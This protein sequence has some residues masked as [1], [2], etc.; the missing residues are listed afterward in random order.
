MSAPWG[1]YQTERAA[2]VDI[3]QLADLSTGTGR[4]TAARDRLRSA[5]EVAGVELGAYD[6]QVIAWLA[7]FELQTVQVVVGLIARAAACREETRR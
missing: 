5:C 2:L 7:G 3:G 4:E 6:R 1:P